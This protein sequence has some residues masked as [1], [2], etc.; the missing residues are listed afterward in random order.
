ME[1]EAP[2]KVKSKKNII[3]Q[4]IFAAVN[5]GVVVI[6]A[7]IDFGGGTATV[8]LSDA[9]RMLKQNWPYLLAALALPLAFIGLDVTKYTIMIHSATKRVAPL[10]A[11]NC[12][13]LGRYYDNV[14]PLG[15]GGQP[16]QVHYLTTKN[17]ESGKAMAT[18]I[19]TFIIQQLAFTV[20]GP[21]FIIRFCLSDTVLP[22]KTLFIVMSWVGYSFYL[23]IP[24]F[25]ILMTV[26]PSIA[27]AIANFFI[28]LLTKM[29]ILRHPEKLEERVKNSLDR[30]RQ[31]AGYITKNFFRVIIVFVISILQFVVF[32]LI[33]Y[34]VCRALGATAEATVDLFMLMVAAYFAITIIPTPGNS[35]AAEFSFLAVFSKVLQG[36]V[37]WG[38]LLWR[39]LVYYLYLIQGL[40]II[41]SRTIRDARRLKLAGKQKPPMLEPGEAQNLIQ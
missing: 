13:Q 12:S 27:A 15:A 32:F 17:I 14:T 30:Y 18:V 39:L 31:T 28:R 37:F 1:S 3:L 25:L 5:I 19:T 7:T 6:I 23:I 26:K 22:V 9:A 20:M 34:C 2:K 24:L 40:I 29:K 16:F 35:V 36:N 21:Y 41:V 33:P 38:I 10:T 8:P 11:Y 4:F